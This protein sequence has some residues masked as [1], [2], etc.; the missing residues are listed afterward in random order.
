[1]LM[2]YWKEEY[3]RPIHRGPSTAMSVVVHGGLIVL[4]V[5]ATNPPDGLVQSLYELANRVVYVAPPPRMASTEGSIKRLQFVDAGPIGLGSGFARAPLPGPEPK[6]E[7]V[8][9]SPTP[10]DM[11]TD[12]VAALGARRFRGLDSVFTIVEVDSAV[13][14]D[15]TSIAPAYPSALLKLGVE[16]SVK[17]RYVVDSTGIA[18]PSTLEVVKASRVEFAVAVREALPNMR[19]VAAKMGPRRVRQLVEQ[20]FNFRIV[21]P[22]D[23][24]KV[25]PK[26]P[27]V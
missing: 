2:R 4:A 12:L 23:T 9:F 24:V 10:G 8:V 20:E 7:Q 25:T 27:P 13:A 26:K 1:M 17:V 14:T 19:F 3:A 16:G 21:R 22:V 6:K 11:G 5:I 18:D 15:P